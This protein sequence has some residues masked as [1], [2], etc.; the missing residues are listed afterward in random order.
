MKK[1]LIISLV[2]LFFYSCH[3]GADKSKES[4]NTDFAGGF[5]IVKK[6]NYYKLYIKNLSEEA[7]NVSVYYLFPDSLMIP[8]SLK[9]SFVIRIPIKKSVCLSTTYIGF[10]EALNERNSIVGASSTKY[11][12]DSILQKRVSDGKIQE[13]GAYPQINIETIIKLRPDVVF[14]Y[15]M[16]GAMNKTVEK[17]EKFGI[18]V[19][20]A[21][22]YLENSPLARAE[23]IKVFG[24]FYD[25]LTAADSIFDR[26]K[27]AYL[28]EKEYAQ[29][30]TKKRIGVLLN[31]PFQGVW[32]LPGGDSYMARLIAD[33]GAYYPW[34]SH[35]GTKSFSV[36]FEEIFSKNDLLDVL[37]NTGTARSLND[38]YS[39]D[40][41]LKDIKC[42][43]G[44][45]VWNNNKRVNKYGGND[46]FESG[47][48]YP[49]K[50]LSDLIKI[51]H[52][53]TMNA[54]IQLYYYKKLKYIE[55]K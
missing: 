34:S 30:K 43:A 47:A 5:R 9:N 19:V 10:I 38:I 33:A 41:R 52:N 27:T 44:G 42:I 8:D 26:V 23:W 6:N 20:I 15:D 46:F 3:S 16:N 35:K 54:D 21:N 53:Q 50:I 37:I 25:K 11:I 12:Y 18:P 7:K 1:I 24:L 40:S 2:A 14:A 49:N 13:L 4:N 22:D 48:V 28:K 45:N 32:Y 55:K 29:K 39:S 36:S 17:L 51:F 31:I